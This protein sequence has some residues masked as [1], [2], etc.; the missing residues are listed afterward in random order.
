M[1][2]TFMPLVSDWGLLNLKCWS[3][4]WELKMTLM[5]YRIVPPLTPEYFWND[6]LCM[7]FEILE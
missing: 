5:F 2:G 7:H 6:H 1:T 3:G 4:Q